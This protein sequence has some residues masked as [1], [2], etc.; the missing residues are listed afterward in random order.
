MSDHLVKPVDQ[1]RHCLFVFL[2]VEEID[3]RSHYGLDGDILLRHKERRH[4][5]ADPQQA[6]GGKFVLRQL[7][8][9][10]TRMMRPPGDRRGRSGLP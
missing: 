9:A 2:P 6:L 10:E 8:V 1:D 7:V 4:D 3:E 5:V